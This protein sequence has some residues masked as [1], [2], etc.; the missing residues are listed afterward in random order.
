MKRV[1]RCASRPSLS[2]FLAPDGYDVIQVGSLRCRVL[3]ISK[4]IVAFFLRYEMAD[5][6]L[7]AVVR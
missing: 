1:L 3:A 2:A 4:G 5:V 7:M 6:P